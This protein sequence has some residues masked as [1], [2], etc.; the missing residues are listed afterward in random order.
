MT[1]PVAAVAVT[2]VVHVVAPVAMA[3][4][5]PLTVAKAAEEAVKKQSSQP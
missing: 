1:V 5:V 3:A 2:V 4:T